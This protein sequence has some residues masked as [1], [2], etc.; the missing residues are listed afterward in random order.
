M[1]RKPTRA[2]CNPSKRPDFFFTNITIR[3]KYDEKE[4]NRISYANMDKCS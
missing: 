1:S 3:L 4:I 2:K